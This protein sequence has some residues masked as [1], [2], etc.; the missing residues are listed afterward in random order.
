MSYKNELADSDSENQGSNPCPPAS[1]NIEKAGLY[2]PRQIGHLGQTAHVGRTEVGTLDGA[3]HKRPPD[4][5]P[6]RKKR[7]PRSVVATEQGPSRKSKSSQKLSKPKARGSQEAARLISIY[8]GRERLASV[9]GTSGVFSVV[10]ATGSVLGRFDT[11][12]AVR[13][14]VS[15][16]AGGA[17]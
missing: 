5:P 4:D 12:A 16:A 7:R 8:A 13:A 2:A 11:L 15:A 6:D 9:R 3:R 10:M 1:D 17:R 14:A